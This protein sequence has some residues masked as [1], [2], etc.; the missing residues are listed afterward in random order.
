MIIFKEIITYIHILINMFNSS[1]LEN[2]LDF[3]NPSEIQKFNTR[4]SSSHDHKH[5]VQK[6]SKCEFETM[7]NPKNQLVSNYG[8][9]TIKIYVENDKKNP[10]KTS[11]LILN[12]G[13]AIGDLRLCLKVETNENIIISDLIES[14]ELSIGPTTFEKIYGHSIMQLLKMNNMEMTQIEN[15]IVLPLPFGLTTGNNIIF[16][17]LLKNNDIRL[18][19]TFTSK[20]KIIQKNISC[21]Y[22][23]YENSVKM[24]EKFNEYYMNF[25]NVNLENRYLHLYNFSEISICT[26]KNNNIANFCVC[27]PIKDLMFYFIDDDN[28]IV[29][30]LF[31]F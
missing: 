21:V 13:K 26:L 18:H 17:E 10:L 20:Y 28:K 30:S 24:E 19:I 25:K 5:I 8:T 12:H 22:Y 15:E 11:T 7:A 27:H 14:I 16:K 31:I 9:E 1:N 6:L 3:T 2:T 23:F 29:T 4:T